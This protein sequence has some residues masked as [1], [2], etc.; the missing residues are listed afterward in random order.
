MA[1]AYATFAAGGTFWKDGKGFL[2]YRERLGFKVG[3]AQCQK[4]CGDRDTDRRR[5]E[6]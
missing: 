6:A 3:V 1:N 2:A 5:V 4:G